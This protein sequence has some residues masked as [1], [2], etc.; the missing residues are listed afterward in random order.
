[1]EH[2]LIGDLGDLTLEQLHDKINELHRK[3]SVAA[4]SGNGNLCDQIRMA[5]ESY[6]NRAR[7]IQAKQYAEA[8]KNFDDKI[9]ISN[10]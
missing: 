2:P 5:I 7:E 4:R 8:Q 10:H 9:N 3:L 6:S 1:M